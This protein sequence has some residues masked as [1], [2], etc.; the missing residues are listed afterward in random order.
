VDNS[1]SNSVYKGLALG[2]NAQGTFLYATNFHLGTVDVFDESFNQVQLAGSFSDPQLPPPSLGSPGF[3][4]FGIQNIGGNLFVTYALQKPDQ[5]DDQ[6][7]LSN[8]FVDVFDTD[9]N[10]LSRFASNGTLNSPWGVALA[11]DGFGMFSGALLVGN[12]G[13]GRI[14]AFDS[15]TGAFLGQLPD[16]AGQPISIDGLWGITFQQ[17]TLFFA[18]G[19]NGE[20]DGLMGTLG[21]VNAGGQ[22]NPAS[23]RR[24]QQGAGEMTGFLI[25]LSQFNEAPTGTVTSSTA[26]PAGPS[27]VIRE[28]R[29]LTATHRLM[30]DASVRTDSRIAID[31]AFADFQPILFNHGLANGLA[32]SLA[33]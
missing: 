30:D 6:A 21:A 5:H 4:P 7:G 13:D 24:H 14:N 9:G 16:P 18:A 12:F 19:I 32:D 22:A 29:A 20:A 3:A 27:T 11:P 28:Q 25:L 31:R 15:T 33:S 26:T 1:A 10:L 8:G 23:H 17:S 2:T